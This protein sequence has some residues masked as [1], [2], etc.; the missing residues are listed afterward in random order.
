MRMTEKMVLAFDFG[1]RRIG[2]AVGE[3]LTGS[4]RPLCT[5]HAQGSRDAPWREISELMTTWKPACIIVG[6]PLH[7]DG[8]ESPL[9]AETRRFGGELQRRFERPTEFWNEALTSEEARTAL[10]GERAKGNSRSYRERLNAAAACEIL[11]SWLRSRE[12]LASSSAR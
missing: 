8:G 2:V 3:T 4:A 1:R 11:Q 7:L 12:S 10:R 9:A 5:L 6:L